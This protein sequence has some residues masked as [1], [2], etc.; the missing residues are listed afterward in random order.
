M[1]DKGETMP[2]GVAVL[3]YSGLLP[4]VIFLLADRF[5]VAEDLAIAA[6]VPVYAALIF[7]FLGGTWWAFACREEQPEPSLLVLAV[8]PSLLVVLLMMLG[9]VFSVP[10][11]TLILAAL[12]ALS[13]LVDA[14]L[15]TRGLVPDWWMRLR[16]HLSMGLGGLTALSVWPGGAG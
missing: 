14:L 12:I 10:L 7:S 8:T 15:K 13:P 9:S 5:N 16:F 6:L 2:R 1:D 4:P 11:L 3:G